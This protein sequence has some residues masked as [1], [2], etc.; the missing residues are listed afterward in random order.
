MPISD[1]KRMFTDTV[2]AG[3]AMKIEKVWASSQETELMTLKE[4]STVARKD[5]APGVEPVSMVP[6]IEAMSRS[7]R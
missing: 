7:T 2:G 5:D 1:E 6:G 4:P 3:R